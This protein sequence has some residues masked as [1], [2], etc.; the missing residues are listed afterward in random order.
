MNS[1]L[2]HIPHSSSVIPGEYL[3]SFFPGLHGNLLRMT[4]WFTDGLFD[5]PVKRIVFPISRLICDV[6][7]FRDDSREK[8]ADRGMGACYTRGYD[9]R[10]L[11]RLTEREREEILRRWYDPHHARLESAVAENLGRY[12]ECTIIDCHSFSPVPLPYEPEQNPERPDICIGTDGFHTP[13]RLRDY[14][15]E[16]F[17]KKGYAVSLNEPYSG[18][19]VPLRYFHADRRVTSVM[20]EVNRG[21]YLNSVFGRSAGFDTVRRDISDVLSRIR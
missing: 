10:P 9:G 1:V 6:E 11:R 15:T 18:T 17:G 3:R 19:M 2:L 7:R 8:M 4:D 14:L 5:L 13:E 12:G 21:L 20:I 16:S